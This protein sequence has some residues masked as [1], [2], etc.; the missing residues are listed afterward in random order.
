MSSGQ[1]QAKVVFVDYRAAT[2]GALAPRETQRHQVS[3]RSRSCSLITVLPLVEPSLPGKLNVI[4][5]VSGQGRHGIL[6]GD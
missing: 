6:P 1:C 3:V 4:R 2:G 5:S